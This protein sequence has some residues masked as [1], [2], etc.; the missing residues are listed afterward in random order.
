MTQLTTLGHYVAYTAV[1]FVFMYL[2]KLLDDWRT[3]NIDE[4]HE[5]EEENNGA[6][7]IRKA[8]LYIAMATAMA[9]A[10]HGQSAGFVQDLQ[11]LAL[12][13]CLVLGALFIA[14]LVN[15]KI[16]LH[17]IDNDAEVGAKN[18]AVAC[19]EF[20][21]YFA[22]GLIMNGAMT[23][24]GPWYSTIVFFVLAQIAMVV[25]FFVYDGLTKFSVREEIGQKKNLAAGV[26]VG[27]LLTALG[28]I[29]QTCCSGD[30]TSWTTDLTM[31]GVCT[32]QGIFLLMVF[33]WL[34]DKFFLPNTDLHTEIARD[35]NAAA[36]CVAQAI[37]ISLA[38][39]I[40]NTV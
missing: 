37:L 23:G 4:D 36:I 10:L 7:A 28:I 18:E 1:V 20:G 27:G 19:A 35:Q 8:G 15:D 14:F 21:S 33:R 9:G 3:K 24:T 25:M 30:F 29:L 38:I 6:V 17:G 34:V 40:A 31:F 16:M 11:T 26:A 22:T 2:L 32:A 39:V 12:D 13:G 5:I